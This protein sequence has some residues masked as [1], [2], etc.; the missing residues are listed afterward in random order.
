M[1]M[2]RLYRSRDDKK[3]FGLCGGLGQ[4][5]G[6]DPTWI[7]LGL[8]VVT[9]FTGLPILLYVLAAMIV[10]KEPFWGR[11]GDPLWDDWARPSSDSLDDEIDRLEKRAL[12]QE[13]YRLRSELAKY[14]AR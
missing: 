10:P 7:R 5:V 14:Q 1:Q 4:Y 9:L 6:V 3:L 2:N 11:T 13:V 12:Q 8:V